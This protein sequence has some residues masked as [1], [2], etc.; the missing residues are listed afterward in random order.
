MNGGGG[1]ED[2]RT[3]PRLTPPASGGR[4]MPAREIRDLIIEELER[5]DL[6]SGGARRGIESGPLVASLTPAT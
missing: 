1:F 4:A 5:S 3:A 2:I 6:A